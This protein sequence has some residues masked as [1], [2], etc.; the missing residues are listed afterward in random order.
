LPP[1]SSS[2]SAAD[3]RDDYG[4]KLV[5]Q[6]DS[7]AIH[8]LKGQGLFRAWPKHVPEGLPIQAPLQPGMELVVQHELV[9]KAP[10]WVNRVH[11]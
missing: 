9:G 1:F 7:E 3:R 10:I 2:R 11:L 8:V 5:E 4:G 6:R